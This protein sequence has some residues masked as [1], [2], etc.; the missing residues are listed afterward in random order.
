MNP[1]FRIVILIS[2]DGSNLQ[3]IIDAM[4]EGAP[5]Q[6]T[7]VISNKAD[8]YGLT[9]AKNAGIPTQVINH[10]AFEDRGKFD[11]TLME[12]IDAYQPQLVVLAGFMRR[13][14]ENFVNHYEGKMINIH[15]SLLPKYP[16]LHTHRRVLES[17]DK[18]HGIS[19]HYVTKD[20]DSGPII[21]QSK[22]TVSPSDT[23]DSLKK[24]IHKLEHQR[25]PNVITDLALAKN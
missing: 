9:R 11:Q 18:E 8:A 23:E 3:A 10:T 24:R 22:L 5:Y 16:G 20:V 12:T 25:Y 4:R 14:G 19:I 13:L 15:P 21:E 6:I 7:A 1:P 17:G 2:G